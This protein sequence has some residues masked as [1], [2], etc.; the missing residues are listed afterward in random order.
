[1]TAERVKLE[2]S[3]KERL[4]PLFDTDA[5]K[6]LREFL[7]AQKQAGKTIYPAGENIFAAVRGMTISGD[8][9]SGTGSTGA[10][11]T[12]ELRFR[13]QA[14]PPVIA[15]GVVT[16]AP[17]LVLDP[18]LPTCA[19]PGAPGCGN[20]VLDDGEECDD[21]NTDA[22]DGCS[23]TCQLEGCGNH[24]VE[25]GIRTLLIAE[26]GLQLHAQQALDVFE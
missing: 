19:T 17:T 24:R 3:W 1:V 22:C 18:A 5:M 8:L 7:L 12:N 11:G 13:S 14:N 2:P 4:G 9:T 23:P 20:G 26:A 25:C 15:D 16:P 6:R 21:F 10:G